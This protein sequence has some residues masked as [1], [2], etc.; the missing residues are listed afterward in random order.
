MSPVRSI[1]VM[2]ILGVAAVLTLL[3]VIKGFEAPHPKCVHWRDQAT[4]L[5]HNALDHPSP[6]CDEWAP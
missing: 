2:I 6:I 4:D 5:P 1:A 3:N